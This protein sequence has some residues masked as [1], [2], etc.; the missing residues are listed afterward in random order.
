MD[1]PLFFVNPRKCPEC[2][3]THVTSCGIN[4][5]CR[6]CGRRFVKKRHIPL[7]PNPFGIKCRH[8]SS[9]NI[10][11]SGKEQ[12]LC[13]DCKRLSVKYPR[14]T[15][16][17]SKY[18]SR[19]WA[20]RPATGTKCPYCN[21]T[22]IGGRGSRKWGCKD[23][24]KQWCREPKKRV[25]RDGVICPYCGS[26]HIASRG[27]YEWSCQDC[28]RF[29][30]KN[31][32]KSIPPKLPEDFYCPECGGKNLCSRGKCW[33]CKDCLRNIVKTSRQN[34]YELPNYTAYLNN[35]KTIILK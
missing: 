4:W 10:V 32:R 34:L 29:F 25:N 11:S 3:N 35:R 26:K 5:L 15:N 12:W 1:K 18:A 14:M 6:N 17:H 16:L 8:C 19:S 21:S 24:K 33:L 9:I 7:P 30:V 20:I 23:C 2:N 28:R 13:R 27:W 31:R 22:N